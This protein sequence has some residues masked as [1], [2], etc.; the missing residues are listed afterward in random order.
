MNLLI[1]VIITTWS[2]NGGYQRTPVYEIVASPKDAGDVVYSDQQN[3][4]SC[5]PDQ[6]EYH[7][8]SIDITKNKITKVFLPTLEFKD[9][10]SMDVNQKNSR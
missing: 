8:Y 9:N 4:N 1:L 3:N 10:K 5:E 6:K 2:F 7:L